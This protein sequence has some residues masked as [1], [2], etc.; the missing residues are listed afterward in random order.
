MRPDAKADRGYLDALAEIAQRIADS[1]GE[2]HDGEPVGMYV[3][4]GAAALYY[5]GA[6][7]TGDVDAAFS[8]RVVL[9]G[10]LEVAYRDRDGAARQVYLDRNYNE[11][12]GLIHERAHDDAREIRLA[13]VD[14]ARLRVFLLS[15]LDLAVSKLARFAE[16]DRADILALAR[17]G[18]ITAGGLRRRATEALGGY[19]GDVRPVEVNID[20]ACAL[21]EQ[22]GRA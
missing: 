15:P 5:T 12:F 11:S 4:G 1:L 17:K 16:H 3:A 9:P 8:R 7:T 10:A 13:G 14:R 21:L 22:A 2:R 6:R 18:L 20:L 19:V